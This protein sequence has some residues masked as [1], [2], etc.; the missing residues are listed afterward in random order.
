MNVDTAGTS[1]VSS[2]RNRG[3]DRLNR[4]VYASSGLW[5]APSVQ[6]NEAVPF[7]Q[8]SSY[9]FFL[10]YRTND[11]R[12]SSSLETS[13]V[14]MTMSN[15]CSGDDHEDEFWDTAQLQSRHRKVANNVLQE[16]FSVWKDFTIRRR[17]Y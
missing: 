11:S 15:F 14:G 9:A 12:S 8:F 1:G 13:S 2:S 3:A 6:L 16:H 10:C 4:V 7:L 17:T 5:V